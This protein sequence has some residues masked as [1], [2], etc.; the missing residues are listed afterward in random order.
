MRSIS[1][2]RRLVG[3]LLM[4]EFLSALALIFAAALHEYR[5]QTQSFDASLVA[6]SESL[7]GAVQDA[8]DEDDR[9]L[10]DLRTARVAKAALFRVEDEKGR[11]LGAAGDTGQVFAAFA[12]YPGFHNRKIS[13]HSYRFYTLHG[14]RITDPDS[15]DGGTTHHIT[16]LYGIPSGHVWNEVLEEIRFYTIASAVMSGLIAVLIVGVIKKRLAPVHQLAVE[17]ERIDSAN[18]HFHAPES[19]KETVEL[20]PLARALESALERVQRSF[21]QQKRFTNDAA[22]ELKTDLAIVKSSLQ[23]LSMRRPTAEYDADLDRILKDFTRLEDT[24]QKLLTLAR[25]EQSA[26]DSFNGQSPPFCSLQEAA[27]EAAHQIRPFA[28]IKSIELNIDVAAPIS[29]VPIDR[30][31]AVLLCSNLL[32]NAAQH[33]PEG[34]RV[35]IEL[36]H[37][38]DKITLAVRDWGEGIMEKDLPHLLHPFY[39]SDI[40]R[41]RKSGGT[42]L[43]LSICKAICDNSGGTIDIANHAEGGARVT[44][45]FPAYNPSVI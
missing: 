25:L 12:S 37:K 31:D 34:G 16:I 22:H 4:L 33:S 32:M 10:L 5:V 30:R 11:V 28:Q 45:V 2:A 41:S 18:W 38:G 17:A 26:G 43:G 39:R 40:S 14:L 1:I 24:V 23:L 42:G 15:L 13:G 8:E 35:H 44:V 36:S 21:E 7:M 6:D 3:T 20:R 27:E 19:A 9:L 29:L